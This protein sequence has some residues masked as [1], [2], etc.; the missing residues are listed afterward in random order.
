MSSSGCL[1]PSYWLDVPRD[2]RTVVK[3]LGSIPFRFSRLLVGSAL[4]ASLAWSC[5]GGGGGG[6]GGCGVDCDNCL[7]GENLYEC[8]NPNGQPSSFCAIDDLT[9]DQHCAA[10]G[11]VVAGKEQCPGGNASGAGGTRGNDGT[12][13]GVDGTTELSGS[14][15]A[16]SDE[17]GAGGG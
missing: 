16:R 2:K 12:A 8:A 6:C 3:S 7:P 5:G 11:T 14:D 15:T 17:S 4:G 13:S 1:S 9:A 10:I